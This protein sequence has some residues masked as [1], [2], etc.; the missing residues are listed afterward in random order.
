MAQSERYN[1]DLVSVSNVNVA[2]PKKPGAGMGM[3]QKG[4][5]F[6]GEKGGKHHKAAKH[7]YTGKAK[8]PKSKPGSGP[9]RPAPPKKKP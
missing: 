8:S 9:A 1:I 4:S 6:K 3:E 7:G 2:N 5:G